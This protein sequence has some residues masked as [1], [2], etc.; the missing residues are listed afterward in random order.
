MSGQKEGSKSRSY[1]ISLSKNDYL[2]RWISWVVCHRLHCLLQTQLKALFPFKVGDIKCSSLNSIFLYFM[3]LLNFSL[4]LSFYSTH[5]STFYLT[6]HCLPHCLLLLKTVDYSFIVWQCWVSKANFC[7]ESWIITLIENYT[8][9]G[10]KCTKQCSIPPISV[11]HY[12]NSPG[13]RVPALV[14][15]DPERF[16]KEN[17]MSALNYKLSSSV[18][19]LTNA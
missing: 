4:T 19:S 9:P 1:P 7:N 3:A 16:R 8:I 6:S 5:Y 2:H 17:S 10:K 18:L 13:D 11:A 14:P 12:T 15:S